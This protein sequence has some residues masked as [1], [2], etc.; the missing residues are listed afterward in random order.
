MDDGVELGALRAC[1]R[2]CVCV[3][4]NVMLLRHNEAQT[5]TRQ[6]QRAHPGSKYEIWHFE[7]IGVRGERRG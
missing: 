5:R 7:W 6:G 2:V 3:Q 1:V 4:C